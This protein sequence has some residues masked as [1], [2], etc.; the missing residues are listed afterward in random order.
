MAKTKSDYARE[1][2]T[3]VA[4]MAK[5]LRVVNKMLDQEDVEWRTDTLTKRKKELESKL[6]EAEEIIGHVEGMEGDSLI[7]RYIGLM[8]DAKMQ[9]I[10]GYS[11][12]TVYRLMEQGVSKLYDHIPDEYRHPGKLGRN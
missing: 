1:Y 10:F 5:D 9:R 2:L 6:A 12:A 8:G 4:K 3:D 11:R 7:C